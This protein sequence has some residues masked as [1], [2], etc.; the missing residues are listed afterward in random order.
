MGIFCN[1][2]RK[3]RLEDKYLEGKNIKA[4]KLHDKD[5][6]TFI[7]KDR[8]GN[9]CRKCSIEHPN[10]NKSYYDVALPIARS[11]FNN[12]ETKLLTDK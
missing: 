8:N 5:R 7:Q 10:Y 4:A 2:N 1:E 3:K 9:N 12:K 6:A 11:Y